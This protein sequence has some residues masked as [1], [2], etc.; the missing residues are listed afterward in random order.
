MV[1][2]EAS[3]EEAAVVLGGGVLTA[4][5]LADVVQSL[6]GGDCAVQHESRFFSASVGVTR[7]KSP[8]PAPTT[9]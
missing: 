3:G 9:S 6:R 8:L 2:P 1:V 5:T 7:S 4:R